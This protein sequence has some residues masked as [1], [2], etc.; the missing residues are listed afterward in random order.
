MMPAID[1][2]GG[3]KYLDHEEAEALL[4]VQARKYFG[5]SGYHFQRLYRMGALNQHHT[6]VN[7]LSFLLW[8]EAAKEHDMTMIENNMREAERA[9][10]NQARQRVRIAV[11]T[12]QR[13]NEGQPDDVVY[14]AAKAY[15]NIYEL[16]LDDDIDEPHGVTCETEAE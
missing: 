16:L 12:G 15:C 6:D 7:R 14:A 9:M 3:V 13:D 2:D 8:P 11:D 4:D 10:L 1:C 5:L